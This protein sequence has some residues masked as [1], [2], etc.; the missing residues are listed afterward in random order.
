MPQRPLP[1]GPDPDRSTRTMV[2]VFLAVL[3]LAVVVLG[4]IYLL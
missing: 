3:L 1:G 4:M 2:W